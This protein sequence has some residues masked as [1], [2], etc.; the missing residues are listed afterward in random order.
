MKPQI[1]RYGQ[2]LIEYV[3]VITCIIAALIA[4]QFYIKRALQGR[5][6]SAADQIG[7]QYEPSR[8]R[9]SSTTTLNRDVTT[10]VEPEQDLT[11]EGEEGYATFR[12]ETIHKDESVRQGTETVDS[13]G[14]SLWE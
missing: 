6:R 12:T 8:T 7:E 11:V 3:V 2:T 9:G 5:L 14:T 13:F 1:K 4:T 10:L